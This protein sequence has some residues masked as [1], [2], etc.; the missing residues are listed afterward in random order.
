MNIKVMIALHNDSPIMEND[1]HFPVFV[2]AALSESNLQYQRDDDG[3][4]ISDKNRIYCELT[5]AY[6][7]YKNLKNVY[8]IGLC[9]YRRYFESDGALL[10]GEAAEKI[11]KKYPVIL[12][13]K[14]HYYIET[15]YSQFVHAHGNTA[16]D[17]ARL[18]IKEFHPEYLESFDQMMRK[19]ALHIYNMFIMR[20]DIFM[21]YCEFLFDILGKVEAKIKPSDRMLGFLGE[22][23]L[24]VYILKNKIEYKE[25]PII[26]NEKINWIKKIYRFLKRK[27]A[28]EAS[29]DKQA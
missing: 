10:S 24:D 6:W 4:N 3:E 13:K 19:R 29:H 18:A 5:A 8:Y 15:V 20:E 16:I 12:P 21:D 23:L 28:Y 14:R 11:L 26:S 9:H 25:L 17:A 2:G 7:A 1:I 27:Y 22:R